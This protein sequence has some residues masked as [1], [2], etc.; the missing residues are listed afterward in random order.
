MNNISPDE[1]RYTRKRATQLA[2]ISV[3][4]LEM[5]ET[6]RFI[7]VRFTSADQPCYSINDIRQLSLIRRLHEDLEIDFPALEVV[8]NL[9]RQLLDLQEQIDDLERQ[10]IQREEQLRREL[11]NLRRRFAD[12]ADWD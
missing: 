7:E 2:N 8:L 11:L 3:Q 9:R 5:C 6:E 12:E 1:P 4:F 10:A